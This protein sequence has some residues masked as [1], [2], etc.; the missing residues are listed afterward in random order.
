MDGGIPA[1]ICQSRSLISLSLDGL[2]TS[3]S[4]TELVFPGLSTLNGFI[5]S[6]FLEGTIPS[7]LYEMPSLELLHLSGNGL[8][9]SIPSNMN[10][11]SQL[12]NLALS[13]NALTGTIP[14]TVQLRP[15]VFLDLSY[16]KLSGT[17]SPFFEAPPYNSSTF[18]EVN[19]LSGQIPTTLVQSTAD[20][21]ILNGNIF[22]CNLLGTDLPKH[23]PEVNS[24]SCG[25]DNANNVLY[26]WIGTIVCILFVVLLYMRLFSKM[27]LS[28]RGMFSE[29]KGKWTTWKAALR[30]D[31]NRVNLTRLSI[32]FSEVR[33]G[34]LRLTAYC[35]LIL[36]PVYSLLKLSRSSYTI[37][38]AWRISAMLMN[39]RTAAVVLFVALMLFALLYV[40]VLKE[41]VRKLNVRMPKDISRKSL[42]QITV[43]NLQAIERILVYSLVFFFDLVLMLLADFSYVF[44]VISYDTLVATLAA[45]ALALFR[46]GTNHI[47]LWYALPKT[48][49]ILYWIGTHC[50]K[51]ADEK[52]SSRL[53][54]EFTASDISF[55]ENLTLF[56]NIIIPG[57]AIIFILPD[58]FYNVLFSAND[59][60]S[61]YSYELCYQYAPAKGLF[62]LCVTGIG[63][64]V[65]S[66]SFIYSYQCSSKIVINYVPVYVLMFLI[67]TIIPFIKITAK[68][69]YQTLRDREDPQSKRFC[70]LLHQFLPEYF[71]DFQSSL[72]DGSIV[73]KASSSSMEGSDIKG[74]SF[75]FRS[76]DKKKR[77][78]SKLSVTVQINSYL[79]ILM[80]FGAL[81]PPLTL[82]AVMSI[83]IITYFEELWI[84]W[85]LTETR[86]LGLGYEWYEEQIERECEGVE[87]SSNLTIWSTLMVSCCL[88]GYMIFDT[89]GD[90]TGWE[91]ALPMTLILMSM[92]VVCYG[93]FRV[94]RT[95]VKTEAP[96]LIEVP[97][98]GGLV[99]D[100]EIEVE[101][102]VPGRFS[103]EENCEANGLS[104][105][106][107]S[108]RIQDE[109]LVI[110]NPLY[111]FDKRK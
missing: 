10:L 32:Y 77:L 69:L 88:Y 67:V 73:G 61:Y 39:G 90:S 99:Q 59:I 9:G 111:S 89:M 60:T 38:Y 71:K 102:V 82:I 63:T 75:F 83:Y 1:E 110:S 17:L 105:V 74:S 42:P 87:E 81:F 72:M 2:T 96:G 76:G 36:I 18:L 15:W 95:W 64:D 25:S 11:S 27:S 58:C 33:Q 4:C 79:T 85:L 92:P 24:Y 108:P 66:P 107:L 46:F 20:I 65:Y 48:S 6:H 22:T 84:G 7:C 40:I 26:A 101:K 8:T 104:M 103:R 41:I 93:G 86:G 62:H 97:K 23:D 98:V 44:V 5:V 16:N 80:C 28:L 35:V 31:E 68:L 47:I 51:K 13:H 50:F 43:R 55:L 56:N 19:R 109:L 100:V 45:L 70:D 34:T 91:G 94:Y 52:L 106:Y 57:I 29:V 12:T 78:F 21:N 49:D 54:L 30:R 14:D 37:E 3:A 53:E